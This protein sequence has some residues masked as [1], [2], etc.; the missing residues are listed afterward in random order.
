MHA[1]RPNTKATAIMTASKMIRFE[2]IV[3]KT[4]LTFWWDECIIKT[5]LSQSSQ[6][7]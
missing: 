4:S 7:K 3:I 2:V 5:V 1:K 6:P